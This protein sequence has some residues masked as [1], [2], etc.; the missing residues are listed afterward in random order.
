MCE[1]SAACRPPLPFQQHS[2]PAQALV[3]GL[4]VQRHRVHELQARALVGAPQQRAAVAVD[5]PHPLQRAEEPVPNLLLLVIPS[6]ALRWHIRLI[7]RCGCG[8]WLALERAAGTGAS[9]R[10]KHGRLAWLSM[11]AVGVGCARASS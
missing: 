9:T 6:F 11:R 7:K 1:C 5:Q 4:L 8:V 10:R 3:G 2:A